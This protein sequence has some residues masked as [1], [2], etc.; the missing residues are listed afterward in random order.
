LRHGDVLARVH[1][2]DAVAA[3][4]AVTLVQDAFTVADE[5]PPAVA[6]PVI[7]RMDAPRG[8]V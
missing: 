6:G 1:A 8:A 4:H 3:R 5:P 7:E 2:A